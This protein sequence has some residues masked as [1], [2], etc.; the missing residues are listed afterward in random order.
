[1]IALVGL[2]LQATPDDR[3][4]RRVHGSDAKLSSVVAAFDEL[5]GEEL[6]EEWSN[7]DDFRER[8]RGLGKKKGTDG[9]PGL[10]DELHGFVLDI[11]PRRHAWLASHLNAK[12]L[13]GAKKPRQRLLRDEE[14]ALIWRAAAQAP[15]PDGPYIQL[16]LLLGARR[17]ELGQAAWSEIDLDRALWTI[18]PTRMKSGEGHCVPCLSAADCPPDEVCTS[19][20]TCAPSS[21]TDR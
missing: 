8:Y 15:Y 12:D 4:E 17:S 5:D 13:I 20:N 9:R 1:M 11:G 10:F 6:L 16:L 2:G 18:P 3:I 19:M 14:L 21:C 7:I